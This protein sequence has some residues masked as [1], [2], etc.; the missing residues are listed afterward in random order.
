MGVHDIEEVMDFGSLLRD[1]TQE[2]LLVHLIPPGSGSSCEGDGRHQGAGGL[3]KLSEG[4]VE[5]SLICLELAGS[6]GCRGNDTGA[7]ESRDISIFIPSSHY[8]M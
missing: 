4:V 7:G 8:L 2:G 3:L 5:C 6:Y 1:P